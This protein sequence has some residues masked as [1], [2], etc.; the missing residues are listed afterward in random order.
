MTA[1]ISVG[2]IKKY[3]LNY[4]I[5]D[6]WWLYILKGLEFEFLVKEK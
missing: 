4:K 2:N 3:Q 6:G 5:L 1:D